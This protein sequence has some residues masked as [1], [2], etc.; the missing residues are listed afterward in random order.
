MRYGP[1]SILVAGNR[2]LRLAQDVASRVCRATSRTMPKERSMY[3][4]IVLIVL[5]L[6]TWTVEMGASC[7]G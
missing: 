4:V 1:G 7:D 2:S 6:F 3:P 5:T